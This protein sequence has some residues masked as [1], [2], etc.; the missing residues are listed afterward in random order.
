[1][2]K[3]AT[4]A[5]I[6]SDLWGFPAGHIETDE[7]PLACIRREMNEELGPEHALELLT[8]LE[9][10]ID[11]QY[12]G[13]YEIHLFHFRWLSGHIQ[14]NTEHT[15]YA[16]VGHKDYARYPTVPGV[17]EDLRYLKIWLPA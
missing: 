16:W 13:V 2:L 5:A 10:V 8:Q 12:G 6:G 7:S 4:T 1:M 9:P 17:D 11:T 14:L 15:D 3:R